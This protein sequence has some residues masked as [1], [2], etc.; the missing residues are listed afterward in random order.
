MDL[1]L[2][3]VKGSADMSEISGIWLS[4]NREMPLCAL[5]LL[6]PESVKPSVQGVSTNTH[7]A[8][9]AAHAASGAATAFG[10]RALGS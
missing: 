4:P 1:G 2:A 5:Y 6:L 7:L 3:D 10:G 8:G 9:D